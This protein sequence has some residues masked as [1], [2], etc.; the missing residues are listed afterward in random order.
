MRGLVLLGLSLAGAL[1]GAGCAGR[2]HFGAQVIDRNGQPVER[3]VVAL[4]PGHVQLVTDSDGWFRV[5]YL[6]DDEGR[7]VR[8]ARNTDYTLEIVKPGFHPY[9]VDVRF[10]RGGVVMEPIVL[11]EDTILVEDHGESLDPA[12]YARPTHAAGANYEGQ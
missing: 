4:D 8:L 1:P 11:V 6:R 7:R 9:R 2:H 3:A 10:R 12:L 5:D